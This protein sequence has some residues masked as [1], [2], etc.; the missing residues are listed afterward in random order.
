M[1]R[2]TSTYKRSWWLP[3]GHLQS[4]WAQYL[5]RAKIAYRRER[6][7]LPDGDF[8]DLDWADSADEAQPLLVF[9][10]GLEGS[11]D[12]QYCRNTMA[13]ANARGWTGVIAHFRGCSGEP[14]RLPRSYH[15]GDSEHCDWAL[16]D[17]H[18]R[19]PRRT[20]FAVG[21][22]LGGNALT[23]W[24]GEQGDAARAI[25][26]AAAS[27]SNPLD[28]GISAEA[29]LHGKNWIFNRY[30]MRAMGAS[31]ETR[32]EQHP[33][34]K[35]KAFLTNPKSFPEFDEHYTAPTHGYTSAWDYYHRASSR[36]FIPKIRVPF[37]LLNA[38]NDPFVPASLFPNDWEVPDNITLEQPTD[39]GHVG[40]VTGAFPGRLDWL[41]HRLCGFFAECASEHMARRATPKISDMTT[42]KNLP[43]EIFKAYD[44]RGIVGK[45]L[46]PEIA[47]AVGQ[48][49]GSL[50][51]ERGADTI[52]VGRDGRLSG[53]SLSQ[54]LRDG[55]TSTGCNAIDLGLVPTPVSYF[56]GH[57]LGTGS[58]VSV[59]GSHNPPDYNGIKMVVAGEAIWGD[60]I[61]SLRT[62]AETGDVKT[63]K[64]TQTVA[65]IRQAY[66]DRIVGD[67]KLSRPMKIAV[68]CGNGAAGELAPKIFRA[69]GC[70]VVDMYCD[71]DGNFPNHH[72]DPSKLENLAELIHLVKTTDVELGL[73]F[74]GDGDRLGVVTKSGEVI[75]P[76]RQMMLFAGDVLSRNPGAT[77]IYDVKS[78]RL[79]D[80]YITDH[81][82]VPLMWKTGHSL[83]KAKLKE[84]GAPLAGEMSGHIFFKERWYGFD[85]AIYC[86]A[87]LLEIV[88]KSE[89]ASKMLEDLPNAPSTPELNLKCAEGEH[90]TLMDQLKA[91]AAFAPGARV[92]TIDGLRVDYAD[93]F[94]LARAS[95][96]TPVIV[97]RFEADTATALARIQDDF[98][99][100]FARVNPELVLPF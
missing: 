83:I 28:L 74:D 62:R 84:T 23:K 54:A 73:A 94:G 20:I 52:A 92:T 71:I 72:P 66:A 70:D 42:A 58:C 41:P 19:F 11:S 88:S 8:I 16:R 85:D 43:S 65:D 56:A 31:Y 77:I 98:R 3:T 75:F 27:V 22:S 5:P 95:N 33:H 86:G 10:H 69:M 89:N 82:G 57:H 32:M 67:A 49:L 93:G 47:Y 24:C 2:I 39:G 63:G 96:T 97:L 79:L 55:I 46:T 45:T 50:S 18:R 100:Q 81:G 38:M 78:S 30:F 35:E 80:K 87:R 64:G 14:N 59:T 40:F 51:Q 12:S 76:D 6:F 25:V 53:P 48:A 29:I 61:Q 60:T 21:V 13:S 44:I 37:L 99:A 9:F 91:K 15:S 17:M 36:G 90:F 1:P 26:T 34:L 4:I 7:E 68:D